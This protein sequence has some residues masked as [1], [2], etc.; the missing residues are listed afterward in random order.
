MLELGTH[1]KAQNQSEKMDT[2]DRAKLNPV[3]LLWALQE[4]PGTAFQFIATGVQWKNSYT[5]VETIIMK[6]AAMTA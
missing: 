6:V 5:V 1:I 2:A 3:M 4:P